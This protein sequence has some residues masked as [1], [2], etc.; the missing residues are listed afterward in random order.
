MQASHRTAYGKWFKE[1]VYAIAPPSPICFGN[2]PKFCYVPLLFD[3]CAL[4]AGSRGTD[5][6]GGVAV[7]LERSLVSSAGAFSIPAHCSLSKH[8]E[9]VAVKISQPRF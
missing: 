7:F 6:P 9:Q 8:K 1:A 5:A 3:D 2:F 4:D